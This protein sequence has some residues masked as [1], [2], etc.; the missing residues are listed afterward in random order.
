MKN[1]KNIIEKFS[2]HLFWDV[3]KSLID[4][5]QNSKYIINSVLQYGFFKDWKLLNTI[6]SLNKIVEISVNNKTL[7]KKTASFLA[8]ISNTPITNFLCYTTKQST[9]KHWNF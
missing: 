2:E 8:L 9:P 7:D 3:E 1:D 6:Y 5:T 4:V